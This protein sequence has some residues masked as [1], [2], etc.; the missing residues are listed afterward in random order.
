[1]LASGSGASNQAAL[2]A[3]LALSGARGAKSTQVSSTAAQVIRTKTSLVRDTGERAEATDK[4]D[5]AGHR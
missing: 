3:L 2:A 1:M 4:R 5:D